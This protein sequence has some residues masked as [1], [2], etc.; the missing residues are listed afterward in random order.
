MC[1]VSEYVRENID[2]RE[3]ETTRERER[4]RE[5]ERAKR[6]SR[7]RGV[8]KGL[9]EV[10]RFWPFSVYTTYPLVDSVLSGD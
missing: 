2:R 10:R 4:E 3:R 5:R 1:S 7:A 6:V 9:V 8:R